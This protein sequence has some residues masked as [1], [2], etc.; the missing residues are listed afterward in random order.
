[1]PRLA[2]HHDAAPIRPLLA[3]VTIRQGHSPA[4]PAAIAACASRNRAIGSSHPHAALAAAARA[5]M[6]VE[7]R[8]TPRLVSAAAVSSVVIPCH[9]EVEVQGHHKSSGSIADDAQHLG[10]PV[11]DASQ[12][13]P[14]CEGEGW[15]GGQADEM[16]EAAL[17]ETIGYLKGQLELPSLPGAQLT[18]W[19]PPRA[20]QRLLAAAD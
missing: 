8:S 1:M 10:Q 12:Q 11:T 3:L 17:D 15:Q 13:R 2:P 9:S 14:G 6:L 16:S 20:Q 18:S 7:S 19:R 5:D 4:T